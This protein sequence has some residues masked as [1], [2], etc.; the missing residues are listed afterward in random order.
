M[1]TETAPKCCLK[2]KENACKGQVRIAFRLCR[3]SKSFLSSRSTPF[4]KV[5][6]ATRHCGSLARSCVGQS[7]GVVATIDLPTTCFP[8]IRVKSRRERSPAGRALVVLSRSIVMQIGPSKSITRLGRE[9][10]M[11]RDS[12]MPKNVQNP[13]H[14]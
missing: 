9:E 13:H 2:K 1:S 6:G 11:S 10:E 14:C 8:V 7:D 3:T 5:T 4:L 12:T